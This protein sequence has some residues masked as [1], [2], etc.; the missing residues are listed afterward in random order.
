MNDARLRASL[1]HTARSLSESGL[2][3]GKSGNVSVR[4]G[5]GF[6]ITPSGIAYDHLSSEQLVQV[7]LQGRWD[8]ALA[9]SSEWHMHQRL[10]VARPDAS[11]LVHAHPLHATA[12]ACTR[13]GIPAFHY[14]VA[15]AGGRDIPCS[16]YATFGTA[17][18]ADE[19]TR[20]LKH[21]KACLIANHGIMAMGRD[22]DSALR[23]AAEVENLAAQYIL[24]RQA[25][26]V[27]LL[28]DAEMDAVIAQFREHY[29]QSRLAGA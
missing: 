20:T 26:E 1:L 7:S 9:P 2:T 25:G 16:G 4:C 22:L 3:H 24:A 13:Q 8:S 15:V 21:H 28:G 27:I 6:L 18:L 17:E 14:M 12:L 11:A 19:V 23:L 5:D 10:Y 29:G